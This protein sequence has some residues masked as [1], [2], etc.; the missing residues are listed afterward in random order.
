M[1]QD[2]VKVDSQDT[3][4]AAVDDAKLRA[5]AVF[6]SDTNTLI[7]TVSQGE[8]DAWDASTEQPN[9]YD[10]SFPSAEDLIEE[11]QPVAA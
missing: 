11:W 9:I 2:S 7:D 10:T 3:L 8:W 4:V 6:G 5:A 1:T